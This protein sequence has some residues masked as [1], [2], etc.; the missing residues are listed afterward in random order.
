VYTL[1]STLFVVTILITV[2]ILLFT[3]LRYYIPGYGSNLERRQVIQLKQQVDSIG[4]LVGAQQ[5]QAENIRRIINGD[6]KGMRDT[7]M[8]R[9]DLIREDAMGSFLPKPEDIK[10]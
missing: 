2:C 4:D 1:F 6:D 10:E 3:P 9:P 7:S 8:L 5:R